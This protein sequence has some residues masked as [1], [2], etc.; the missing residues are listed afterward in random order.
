[1]DKSGLLI[2]HYNK[3]EQKSYSASNLTLG[4]LGALIGMEAFIHH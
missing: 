2:Q 4:L 3:G 1:M